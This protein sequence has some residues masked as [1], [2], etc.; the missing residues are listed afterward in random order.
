MHWTIRYICVYIY[1]SFSVESVAKGITIENATSNYDFKNG[2]QI[3]KMDEIPAETVAA[4]ELQY[5]IICNFVHVENS[6]SICEITNLF[7]YN[8]EEIP[9][10]IVTYWSSHVVTVSAGIS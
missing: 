10:E 6:S 3:Y 7:V 1:S 2:N 8:V 4:C 9:A 5:R